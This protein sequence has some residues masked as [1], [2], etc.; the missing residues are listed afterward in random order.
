M[1]SLIVGCPFLLTRIVT[2]R[3]LFL[4]TS[5]LVKTFFMSSYMSASRF[6]FRP[7]RPQFPII[8][9]CQ[10]TF[11]VSL[12][13]YLPFPLF[14]TLSLSKDG[15]VICFGN[16]SVQNLNFIGHFW[17]FKSNKDSLFVLKIQSHV[18][19]VNNFAVFFFNFLG[20][21]S[22]VSFLANFFNSFSISAIL[23]DLDFNIFS[24]FFFVFA[25]HFFSFNTILRFFFNVYT[26]VFVFLRTRL[27]SFGTYTFTFNFTLYF[28]D[29]L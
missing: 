27:K 19:A 1:K 14:S 13:L 9:S 10:T 12:F 3:F 7:F 21:V 29:S 23:V 20:M 11:I 5:I 8:P 2:S 18:S 4:V 17:N 6:L 24:N 25:V 15:F 28:E 22:L 26:F 16:V